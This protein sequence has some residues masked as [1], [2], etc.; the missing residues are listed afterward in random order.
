MIGSSRHSRTASLIVSA[1]ALGVM[2]C[3]GATSPSTATGLATSSA[4]AAPA[5]TET[6]VATVAATSQTARLDDVCARADQEEGALVYWNSLDNPD[7]VARMLPAFN[8]KYPGI[9]IE[10]FTITP[11]EAVPRIVTESAAGQPITP[12]IEMAGGADVIQPLVDRGLIDTSIDWV[13]D[14]VPQDLVAATNTV[15]THRTAAGLAYNSDAVSADELPDT[16]EELVDPKWR[17]RVIVDPR[18]RPFDQLSLVWG[19]EKTLD[20]ATRL[21][22]VVQP[23][24]IQGATPGVVSLL[25]GEAD[26]A[27]ATRDAEVAQ[28][29]ADGAPIAIKFLEIVPT[30]DQYHFVF[31]DAARP[32]SAECWVAWFASQ[33][34]LFKELEQKVNN[35]TPDGAPAGVEVLQIVTPEDVAQVSKLSKELGQ[36]WTQ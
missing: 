9:D 21:K 25:S 30:Y 23:L 7:T 5:P 3:S 27:T 14:G 36:L 12:D 13:A 22:E 20:F 10:P 6:A 29:Q 15:R 35:T 34:D 4:S 16:W 8:E 28:A 26:I 2:G 11:N 18:G 19:D 17:G 1:I 33:P 32:L 24:V 31:K